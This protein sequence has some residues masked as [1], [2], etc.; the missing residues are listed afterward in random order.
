MFGRKKNQPQP[1]PPEPSW[2]RYGPDTPAR[3]EAA[4]N[5]FFSA[6]TISDCQGPIEALLA[7]AGV[8]VSAFEK[9][10]RSLWRWYLLWLDT[11]A[12]PLARTRAQF[13]LFADEYHDGFARQANAL[14]VAV[15]GTA[16]DEQLQAILN[17]GFTALP[18]LDGEAQ[19]IAA[20]P[21][22]AHELQRSW[23]QQLG[24]PVVHA[25][26]AP[27]PETGSDALDTAL[28]DAEAGDES[29]ALMVAAVMAQ[30]EGRLEEALGFLERASQ[31]GNIDAMLGAADVA[32]ELGRESVARFWTETAANAGDPA[33]TFNMG[34]AALN[35]GD[36]AGAS[37]WLESSAAQGTAEAYAALIEVADR[38]GDAAAQ[39]RWAETGARHDHPRCLEVHA[40][41][42]LR[43]NEADPETFRQALSLMERAASQGYAS[44]MDRCGV[45]YI[46]SGNP[47]QA[48]YWWE[49]AVA[50]GDPD[51]R[52]R[53]AQH[54]LAS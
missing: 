22:P 1:Q 46:H 5:R 29:Q 10:G 25:A 33:A 28:A 12:P 2:P 42:V 50:A 27:E 39:A 26:P 45:F 23:S 24:R 40:L 6:R 43:G 31:L 11:S 37:R 53:L 52:A 48:K 38:S 14:A 20:H 36:M 54:G 19:V 8:G 47:V 3:L 32:R 16:S 44:A 34:L 13:A 21:V 41:N 7:V 30:H 17:S 18:E 35:D 15:L 9:D 49:Q 4:L 51:A